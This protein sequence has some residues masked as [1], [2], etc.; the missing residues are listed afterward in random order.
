[1]ITK[2]KKK[3]KEKYPGTHTDKKKNIRVRISLRFCA[4]FC[5]L[6]IG[7]LRGGTCIL[8]ILLI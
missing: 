2:L 8:L 7:A 4:T 1:M 6:G 3:N 5:L